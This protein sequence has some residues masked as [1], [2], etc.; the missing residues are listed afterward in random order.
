M[1]Y[2]SKAF[3]E[4]QKQNSEIIEILFYFIIDTLRKTLAILPSTSNTML[5]NIK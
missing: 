2:I 1:K 4:S 5:I 3:I